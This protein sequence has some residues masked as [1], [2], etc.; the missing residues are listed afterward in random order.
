[1][2]VWREHPF[3]SENP[4]NWVKVRVPSE[5]FLALRERA[6]EANVSVPELVRM[7]IVWE[8]EEGAR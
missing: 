3:K 6:R 5:E 7:F 8:M 1:M 4:Y 2:A